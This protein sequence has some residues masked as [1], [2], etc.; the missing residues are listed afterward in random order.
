LLTSGLL[1]GVDPVNGTASDSHRSDTTARA[2]IGHLMYVTSCYL[3]YKHCQ[4]SLS[5]NALTRWSVA[6]V[7][8]SSCVRFVCNP[9]GQAVWIE[10]GSR[11]P[12]KK[13]M[14][15]N[16]GSGSYS[17][18]PTVLKPP[19]CRGCMHNACLG[20]PGP[21]RASLAREA[22]QGVDYATQHAIKTNCLFDGQGGCF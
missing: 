11:R 18:L 10:R 17:P 3:G 13:I 7:L 14:L 15:Q 4:L 21:G 2:P 20:L 6:N 22:R 1:E 9:P 19:S 16:T 8:R 12:L 5:W